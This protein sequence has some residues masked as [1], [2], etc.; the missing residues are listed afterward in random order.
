MNVDEQISRTLGCIHRG[1]RAYLA[2]RLEPLGIGAGTAMFFMAIMNHEGSSQ[3]EI[4]SFLLMDKTTTTRAIQKL[5]KGGYITRRRDPHDARVWRLFLSPAGR[6]LVPIL[7]KERRHL[8]TL[9]FK[10]F[11]DEEKNSF[12]AFLLRMANNLGSGDKKP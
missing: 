5:V 2:R 8:A 6:R 7:R 9:L 10:D 11:S 3:E 4:A 1:W 12:H